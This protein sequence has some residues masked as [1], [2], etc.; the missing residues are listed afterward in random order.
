M[1]IAKSNRRISHLPQSSHI[2]PEGIIL[3][4]GPA[5]IYSKGAPRVDSGIFKLGIPML[6]ICYGLQYMVDALGGQVD[7]LDKTRVWLCRAFGKK[8]K[9]EFLTVLIKKLNA[10]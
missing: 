2:N 10:G 5:S 3:S 7:R 4:G 8:A 9:R 1:Y 6:G